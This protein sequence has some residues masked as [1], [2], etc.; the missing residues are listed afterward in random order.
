MAVADRTADVYIYGDITSWVWD[1]SD[2]SSYT[3]AKELEG[4]DV[5]SINVHINSY[6]GEVAEGLAILNTLKAHNAKVKTFCEGFACSAA[7]VVF[8]AGDERIMYP[9]SLLMIH[10]AWTYAS[11]NADDLR[12]AAEDLEIIS[13]VAASAYREKVKISDEELSD[14]LKNET[15]IPPDSAVEWGFATSIVEQT[16]S[17]KAVA[18]ALPFLMRQLCGKKDAE[19][20]T[21]L[22]L[23]SEIAL[24]REKLEVKPQD[25]IKNFLNALAG[26][27]EEK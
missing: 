24:L 21:I 14:L 4:L 2:V 16:Q 25:K 1:E 27:K 3:L 5:D 23:Q 22:D 19:Q 10:N 12:K 6:G 8:M 20:Q 18:S 9:A 13:N 26:Q 17:A 11:G 7:S 15:W